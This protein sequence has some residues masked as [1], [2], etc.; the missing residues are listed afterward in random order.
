M[1]NARS[2]ASR[3]RVRPGGGRRGARSVWSSGWCT[4]RRTSL[5]P[6]LGDV[7]LS[8]PS[9]FS[10]SGFAAVSGRPALEI[11]PLHRVDNR[12][13]LMPCGV[14]NRNL[15]TNRPGPPAPSRARAILVFSRAR[16]PRGSPWQYRRHG[17]CCSRSGL[18]ECTLTLDRVCCTCAPFLEWSCTRK[19]LPLKNRPVAPC[20]GRSAAIAT[21]SRAVRRRCAFCQ[22]P[23]MRSPRVEVAFCAIASRTSIHSRQQ[24]LATGGVQRSSL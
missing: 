15:T 20:V 7:W 6:S 10:F 16:L 22:M 21:G 1:L 9:T 18:A 11:C 13:G 3:R 19:P 8:G 17:F 4:C 5:D 24:P 23:D 14:V 2:A 12:G